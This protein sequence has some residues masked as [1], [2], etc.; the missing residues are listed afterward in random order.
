MNSNFLLG[1]IV[2]TD[3][4]NGIGYQNRLP[5]RC[6]KDLEHFRKATNYRA[7]IMGHETFRSLPGLLSNRYHLVLTRD[8][9]LVS[10]IPNVKYVY[11]ID[12]AHRLAKEITLA[13]NENIAYVIGGGKIY[14]QFINRVDFV[15][16]TRIINN[17]GVYT[18]DTKFV[19]IDPDKFESPITKREKDIDLNTNTNVLLTFELYWAKKRFKL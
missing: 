15:E 7:L 17:H 5:W 16:I 19:D 10:D 8:T 3:T 2:A 13:N 11:S 9:K 6:K 14:E 4:N 1:M 12:E 18:T